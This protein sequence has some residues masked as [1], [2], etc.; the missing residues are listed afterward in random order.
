MPRAKPFILFHVVEFVVFMTA[1][2]AMTSGI[3]LNTCSMR[4]SAEGS[5]RLGVSRIASAIPLEGTRQD[6]Q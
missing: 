3:A 5:L 1:M 2:L 6:E 4:G